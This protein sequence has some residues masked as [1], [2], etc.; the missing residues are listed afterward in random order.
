[1]MKE[2]ENFYRDLYTSNGHIEDDRFENFVHNLE[3]PKLQDLEKE[4]L[5][6]NIT[7][8]EAEEVLKTFSSGKSPGED[9]FTWEFHNCF[10]NLLS[11]D[12]INSYNGAY[13]EGE[14]SISLRRGTITIIPKEDLNLLHLTN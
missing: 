7:L 2:S 12:L 9:K 13:R 14:M 10:F 6:G 5:E 3:I 1:M 8:E 11:E 4:D